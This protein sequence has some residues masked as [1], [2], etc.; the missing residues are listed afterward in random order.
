MG[1]VAVDELVVPGGKPVTGEQFRN[2]NRDRT[3]PV[4][5]LPVLRGYQGAVR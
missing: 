1:V 3:E 5:L 4:E 2:G